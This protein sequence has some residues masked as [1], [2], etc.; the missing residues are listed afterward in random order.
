[1]TPLYFFSG[2]LERAHGNRII[3]SIYEDSASGLHELTKQRHIL[4]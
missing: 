3:A 4:E 1:V 2:S